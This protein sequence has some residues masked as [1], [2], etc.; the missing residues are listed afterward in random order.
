MKKLPNRP[1]NNSNEAC[2]W[3][4]FPDSLP[5][6]F[7]LRPTNWKTFVL[8]EHV[9]PT[10]SSAGGGVARPHTPGSVRVGFVC[11]IATVRLP[12]YRSFTPDL[13]LASA[14]VQKAVKTLPMPVPVAV[15]VPVPA[16]WRPQLKSNNNAR[17]GNKKDLHE[18]WNLKRA[19]KLIHISRNILVNKIFL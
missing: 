12:P 15:A 11:F 5:A 13:G 6:T 8:P 14:S 7:P 1:A 2:P 3:S 16:P 18:K 4:C 19:L 17:H 9:P 10:D